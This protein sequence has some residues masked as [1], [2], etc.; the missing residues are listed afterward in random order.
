[1]NGLTSLPAPKIRAALAAAVLLLSACATVPGTGR[2]QFRFTTLG[3]EM[4]LGAEA[5]GSELEGAKLVQGGPDQ[6]MVQRIGQRIAQAAE[7]LY[8]DPSAE[9]EWEIV[10]IDE[11]KTVNA[12]CLPGG[13][14]AVYTGLL[15]VTQDEDSLAVVVGHEVAHAVA[16]HGGERMSQELTFQL[17]LGIAASS[18]EDMDPDEQDAVL[19]ALIG[20]GTYGVLYPFSRTQENEADELGLYMSAWAGYDPRKAVGLWERMARLGGDKPPEL[21]STHPSD[22]KRIAHMQELMPEALRLY[23]EGKKQ[24]AA[25]G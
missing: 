19:G 9:F 1:M 22:A 21:L 24:R 14:M 5:F 15:P 8:S 20:V 25:G 16:R 23:E 4:S 17:G 11:P 13:K 6:E 12:W 18:M 7:Q 10:L 3:M 2:T